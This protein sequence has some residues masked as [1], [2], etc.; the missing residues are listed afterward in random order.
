MTRPRVTYSAIV[1]FLAVPF[2]L[3]PNARAECDISQTQKAKT[4]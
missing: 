1:I 2:L 3:T 4:P